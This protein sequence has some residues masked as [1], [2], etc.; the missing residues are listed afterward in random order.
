[1]ANISAPMNEKQLQAPRPN[2]YQ[3]IQRKRPRGLLAQVS[4]VLLQPGVFFRTLLPIGETRQWL[5]VGLFILA[6]IGLSAVRYQELAQANDSMEGEFF[7]ADFGGLPGED[8][9]IVEGRD[10]EFFDPGSGG[11][12][13]EIPAGPPS[14]AGTTTGGD[15]SSTWTTALI[16]ASGIV[17]GWLILAVLLCEVSLFNGSSPKLGQNFH[18]AIWASTPLGLMAVLQLAYYAAGGKPGE[19]GLAGLLSDWESYSHLPEFSRALILSFVSRLT[20]FWVWSLILI[21]YGARYVL[22]GKSWSSLLVLVLW[23]LVS[24]ITPV[25]TGAV[26]APV[27]EIPWETEM[28]DIPSELEDMMPEDMFFEEFSLPDDSLPADDGGE[29]E[30]AEFE[31]A[32][33]EMTD[34]NSVES[35]PLETEASEAGSSVETAPDKAEIKVTLGA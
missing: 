31:I 5:L 32:P 10:E 2:N 26:K 28:L 22:K 27:E 15:V 11:F 21:Y 14:D 30:E 23:V 33:D 20:L 25:L 19:P 13:G 24:V 35:M 12:G 17:L 3:L 4:A 8:P 6:L 18:I 29:S 9:G 7:P 16:S 34:S 1:M